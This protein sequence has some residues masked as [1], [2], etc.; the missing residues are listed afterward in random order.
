LDLDPIIPLSADGGMARYVL[1]LEP[2]LA[3]LAHRFN[4]CVRQDMTVPE[5]YAARKS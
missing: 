2:C 3:V 1:H 4:A 5:G